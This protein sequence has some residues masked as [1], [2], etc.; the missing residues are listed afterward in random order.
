MLVPRIGIRIN[1]T[2]RLFFRRWNFSIWWYAWSDT[3][4]ERALRWL[5][6]I[7]IKFFNKLRRY[8]FEV[9]KWFELGFFCRINFFIKNNFKYV[10]ESIRKWSSVVCFRFIGCNCLRNCWPLF[11]I[12]VTCFVKRLKTIFLHFIEAA[13][14]P[15]YLTFLTTWSCGRNSIRSM[16]LRSTSPTGNFRW[17]FPGVIRFHAVYASLVTICWGLVRR[18]DDFP[19]CAL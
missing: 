2:R 7:S 6:G 3:S 4:S 8:R 15:H 9:W 16:Y 10:A 12:I 1:E 18:T 19:G 13:F 14:G 11:R 17:T 5:S